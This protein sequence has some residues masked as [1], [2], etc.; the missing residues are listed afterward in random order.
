ME[1]RSV[2]EWLRIALC[3]VLYTLVMFGALTMVKYCSAEVPDVQDEGIAVSCVPGENTIEAFADGDYYL[4]EMSDDILINPRYNVDYSLIRYMLSKRAVNVMLPA[5]VPYGAE[6]RRGVS[7]A[8]IINSI[9]T[10]RQSALMDFFNKTEPVI[11]QR[12]DGGQELCFQV[13]LALL[14]DFTTMGMSWSV[15]LPND[16]NLL[17]RIT[18]A[19]VVSENIRT[20]IRTMNGLIISK[21]RFTKLKNG[22]IAFMIDRDDR[23]PW[24]FVYAVS[25]GDINN[26]MNP[27]L[28][29]GEVVVYEFGSKTESVETLMEFAQALE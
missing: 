26:I 12:S 24:S 17:I 21:F 9:P 23:Y 15:Q 8:H 13:P 25:E 22:L 7:L 16:I 18:Q 6:Q 11:L 27:E 2:S 5:A 10:E 14:Q 20:A 28:C 4:G 29:E 3:A 1:L 19:N